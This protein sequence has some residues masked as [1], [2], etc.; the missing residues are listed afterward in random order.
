MGSASCNPLIGVGVADFWRCRLGVRDLAGLRPISTRSDPLAHRID[1]CGRDWGFAVR[2]HHL[3]VTARQSHAPQQLAL[4]RL[5]WHDGGALTFAAELNGVLVV[6][7]VVAF[8]LAG[9][10][11][12]GAVAVEHRLSVFEQRGVRVACLG[13]A[14]QGFIFLR[15]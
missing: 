14:P 2:R 6:E 5:T 10:V 1:V 4:I 13:G 15:K 12:F 3:V 11:A 9:A 8:L 7:S